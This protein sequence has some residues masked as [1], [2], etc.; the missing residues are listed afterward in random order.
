MGLALGGFDIPELLKLKTVVSSVR[1]SPFEMR[2]HPTYVFVYLRGSFL[3]ELQK[4]D[5]KPIFGVLL[6]CQ[7]VQKEDTKPSSGSF[8]RGW[9]ESIQEL[10]HSLERQKIGR[11]NIILLGWLW[12]LKTFKKFNFGPAAPLQSP[13]FGPGTLLPDPSLGPEAALASP[14]PGHDG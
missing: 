13:S 14:F 6:E 12:R 3:E 9:G 4:G 5:T 2:L 1:F 10:P 11:R 8:L 7:G